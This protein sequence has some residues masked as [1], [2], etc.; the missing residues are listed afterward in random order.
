MY[1]TLLIPKREASMTHLQAMPNKL[2]SSVSVCVP[3]LIVEEKENVG[4]LSLEENGDTSR[5]RISR[6]KN[7][8]KKFLKDHR[9]H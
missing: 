1:F 4:V 9:F 3:S 6:I 2:E 8:K 7:N 5:T